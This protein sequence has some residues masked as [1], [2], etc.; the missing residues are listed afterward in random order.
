MAGILNNGHN[1][2]QQFSE[3]L[4]DNESD[5]LRGVLQLMR[6]DQQPKFVLAFIEALGREGEFAKER[7]KVGA[8]RD[9]QTPHRRLD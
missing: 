5:T 7:G 6:N 9:A 4:T 1:D 8:R 2:G 3:A